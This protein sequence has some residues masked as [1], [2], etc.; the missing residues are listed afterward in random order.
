MIERSG[1]ERAPVQSPVL[2]II[3]RKLTPADAEERRLQKHLPGLA[4]DLQTMSDVGRAR[5]ARPA[6]ESLRDRFR[7]A[8]GFE[9]RQDCEPLRNREAADE[10]NDANR[11][12]P[13]ARTAPP[14]IQE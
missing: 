1:V 6:D 13:S 5:T 14:C 4:R 12:P 2:K 7:P 3:Q 10:Q 8:A 9:S 11:Q